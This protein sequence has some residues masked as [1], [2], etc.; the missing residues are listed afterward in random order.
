M[1]GHFLENISGQSE[2]V[3]GGKW[4]KVPPYPSALISR[5]QTVLRESAV[6]KIDVRQNLCPPTKRYVGRSLKSEN[7]RLKSSVPTSN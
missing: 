5:L 1:G 3:G 6:G 4:E 7:Y 2:H